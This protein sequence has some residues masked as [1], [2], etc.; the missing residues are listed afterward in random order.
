MRQDGKP[1]GPLAYVF[2]NDVGDQVVSIRTAWAVTCKRAGITGLH[3]HGLRREF[4]SRLL[5]SRADLHEV[6]MFLGHAAI[7]TTSRY[8]QSTPLRLE[9]ALAKLG[10]RNQAPGRKTESQR[11][12]GPA[13]LSPRPC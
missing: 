1:H 4:A 8:L 2:G 10:L 12:F 9:R 11:L 13:I 5:E 6:Q 3:F 7:T